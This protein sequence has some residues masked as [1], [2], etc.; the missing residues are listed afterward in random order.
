MNLVMVHADMARMIRR[1]EVG[2]AKSM[3]QYVASLMKR[4]RAA[5]A[6]FAVLPAVTPHLCISELL[7]IS[8]LPLVNLLEAVNDAARASGSVADSR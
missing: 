8:H 1:A 2:D 7:A 4:L 5:G 6:T 3:G